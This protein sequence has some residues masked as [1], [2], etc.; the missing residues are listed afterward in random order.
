MRIMAVVALGVGTLINAPALARPGTPAGISIGECSEFYDLV[1]TPGFGRPALCVRFVNTATE[2]VRFDVVITRDGVPGRPPG[3]RVGCLRARVPGIANDVP[4]EC[5]A[6]YNL[7]GRDTSSRGSEPRNQGFF[8]AELD[9]AAEYCVQVRAREAD[10]GVVSAR[11]SNV[12]C[13]R[14]RSAPPIPAVPDVSVAFDPLLGTL[15]GR[16]SSQP[17]TRYTVEAR[18]SLA[19]LAPVVDGLLPAEVRPGAGSRFLGSAVAVNVPYGLAQAMDGEAYLLRVCAHT[20][21]GSACS[22]WASSLGAGVPRSIANARRAETGGVADARPSP[23]TAAAR[24]VETS[25]VADAAKSPIRRDKAV[26]TQP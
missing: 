25:G 6:A 8:L 19:R 14:T 9:F 4:P 16:W 21:T 15:T 22:G 7:D 24:A 13:A 12:H 26:A 3:S 2:D 10:S 20:Y 18:A 17:F 23:D 11:W 1:P 5:T